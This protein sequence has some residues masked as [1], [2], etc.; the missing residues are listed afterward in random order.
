MQLK[1]RTMAAAVLLPGGLALARAE[2]AQQPPAPATGPQTPPAQPPAHQTPQQ[3]P[4]GRGRGGAGDVP[5]AAA[6]ARRSGAHRA[7][8]RRSTRVTCSACH[9]ARPAR[10]AAGR[11]E[12]AALA[13]RAERQ[14]GE[15]ILPDRPRRPRREGH[16]ADADV[17]TTTSRPSPSTSTASLATAG[18]R[19][20]PPSDAPPP[21]IV[22]GDAGAGQAYFAAKCSA[23]P[24]ADRRSAGHRDADSR[25]RRR[26]RTAGCRAA[27]GRRRGGR[28]A[29][30][31]GPARKPRHRDRHAAVGRE[32]RRAGS[33]ASTT[34]SSRW[35]RRTAPMRSFR[36]DGDVPKVEIQRSARSRTETLLGDLHR[37]GHARRDRVSGDIEMTLKTTAA[38]RRRCCSP[39]PIAAS[40]QGRGV[41][42][43]GAAQ[44]AR[45]LVADLLRRLLRQALQRADADQPD[46]REEPHAGV[47]RRG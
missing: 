28:G 26:C 32:G 9:G 42:P 24:L 5:R 6:A 40:A 17:P 41:D 25:I 47:G 30:P 1:H 39:P 14:Q 16:A 35:R 3:P 44:A 21:N 27:R 22:V 11:P 19:A 13:G 2:P 18:G 33:C 4:G 45:R 36:R 38:R 23:L 7:R 37:Q 10:R 46:D 31:V 8:Q 12:P 34:S 29:A 15:L 43:A 20:P